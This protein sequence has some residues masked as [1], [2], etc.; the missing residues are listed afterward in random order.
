MD[1]QSWN[2]TISSFSGA[3]IL[4]TWEWGS[5]KQS[6]AWRMFPQTWS[7]S[8]GKLIGAGMFLKRSIPIRGF[9]AR[10]S[11]LYVPRGPLLDWG[12]NDDVNTI[13]NQ[14]ESL[15]RKQGAIFIKIDPDF[16]IGYGIPGTKDA[17]EN[18]PG[19]ALQHILPMR[20]WRF[21]S[22]Q[23]Q[24]RNSVWIDL[25]RSQE[26]ILNNLKQ[27]TRYN[28]H[29]AERK[30]VIIRTAA[31]NDLPALYRMYAETSVRDGFVIRPESYYLQVW[32]K[33]IS[34]DLAHALIA[35]VESQPVAG[36]VLFHFGKRAWY[37]YGMSRNLHREKMPNHLLQ[38]HAIQL[39]CSLGCQVYDLWGAP[40]TFDATDPMWGVYR[41]KEG[42]GGTLVRGI[43]AWDYSPYPSLYA[44][45]TRILPRLLD[46][47]RRRRKTQIR[48]EVSL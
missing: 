12:N 33:F 39:A 8:A 27:K 1:A 38:W 9:G 45:Y 46:I 13:L 3:H 40:D 15:A 41:F 4:Q 17:Q 24:Y 44:L 25:N 43:G 30:G 47:I 11:V 22:D 28:I 7:S 32:E 23:I 5:F 31:F 37:L 10:L 42:F 20:G 26:Q 29:L 2:Q 21:S 18:L 48:H 14:M 16:P 34:C 19:L 6:Y 35:E 36:L